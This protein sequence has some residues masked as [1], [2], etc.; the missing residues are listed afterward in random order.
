MATIITRENGQ[1][2]CQNE[3]LKMN[4]K[5]GE[6]EYTQLMPVESCEGITFKNSIF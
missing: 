2:E 1:I 3:M 4:V 5:T 6:N